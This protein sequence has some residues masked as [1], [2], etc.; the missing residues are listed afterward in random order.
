MPG[1]YEI[2]S[3]YISLLAPPK[4]LDE[5]DIEFLNSVRNQKQ[6]RNEMKHDEE[7]KLL[8]E[9]RSSQRGSTIPTLNQN[10][11][12]AFQDKQSIQNES[13]ANVPFIGK[14]LKYLISSIIF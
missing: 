13:I 3:N 1:N 7:T 12:I 5:E 9:F 2:A 10:P 8:R 11:V 6:I 4:A 14:L